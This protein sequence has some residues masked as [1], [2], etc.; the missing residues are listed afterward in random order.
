MIIILGD[1]WGM[2]EWGIDPRS[3]ETALTGPGIGQYFSLH[4]KV[5]NLSEGGST[6]TAQLM[7]LSELLEKYTPDAGDTFYW[8]ITDPLRCMKHHGTLETKFQSADNIEQLVRTELDSFFDQVNKHGRSYGVNFNLIGG[9]CDLNT[10][11][12]SNY[13]HLNSPVPSWGQLLD[14]TYATSLYCEDYLGEVGTIIHKHRPDLLKEWNEISDQA[15]KKRKSIDQLKL[16]GF[17]N[18]NIHPNR[19]AHIKLR[20]FFAPEYAHK[21]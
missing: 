8:I 1:S 12:L 3:K 11:D 21:I 17:I 13:Q 5:I 4:D 19:Y 20:N 7:W 18:D 2:G 9:R 15:L 16:K 6:N 14:S 10:V